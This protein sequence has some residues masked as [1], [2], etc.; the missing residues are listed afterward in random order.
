MYDAADV[1]DYNIDPDDDGLNAALGGGDADRAGRPPGIRV[2]PAPRGG[3]GGGAAFEP[4][5]RDLQVRGPDK[6]DEDYRSQ[7][8]SVVNIAAI[9]AFARDVAAHASAEL[10]DRTQ[11]HY[12]VRSPLVLLHR[13]NVGSVV[14]VDS[15]LVATLL[16]KSALRSNDPK[17]IGQAPVVLAVQPWW[18]NCDTN[19]HF[20]QAMVTLL[21][22]ELLAAI[23]AVTT[24]L[25]RSANADLRHLC[26]YDFV[27][28]PSLHHHL[29]LLVSFNIRLRYSAGRAVAQTTETWHARNVADSYFAD[30]VAHARKVRPSSDT[31]PN[32]PDSNIAYRLVPYEDVFAL[33]QPK[34]R[35]GGNDL[36]DDLEGL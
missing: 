33:R 6:T 32:L 10:A 36:L 21:S 8:T 12:L 19:A 23:R 9:F 16:E 29:T 13:D 27:R 15:A 26:M 18:Y 5:R 34:Q 1:D 22:D 30:I 25:G 28:S 4:A 3:G 35:R 11:L 24:L 14:A 17:F 7:F 31:L 2:G 20:E